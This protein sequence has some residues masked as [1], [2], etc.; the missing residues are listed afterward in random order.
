MHYRDSL[1]CSNDRYVTL[2]A[3]N[4]CLIQSSCLCCRCFFLVH[5]DS[6]TLGNP[7]N[8]MN[9]AGFLHVALELFIGGSKVETNYEDSARSRWIFIL[10]RISSLLSTT[11]PLSL[12]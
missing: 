11:T 4:C 7:V 3:V 5:N 9:R 1:V 10:M 6:L 2:I 12:S 8:R